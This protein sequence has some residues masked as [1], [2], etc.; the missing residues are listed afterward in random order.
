MNRIIA[1]LGT[2]DSGLGIGDSGLAIPDFR[3]ALATFALLVLI[4]GVSAGCGVR[5]PY[6]APVPAA[7]TAWVEAAPP[8]ADIDALS[9]WW[10]T[11]G[12]PV[13]T[14]LVR[15]AVAGNLEVRT[16]IS[17]LR[18]ARASVVSSRAPLIPTADASGSMRG[19]GR[20][21]DSGLGGTSQ[22]YSLG[23]DASWEID[24][25]GGIRSAIDAATATAEARDA[26][27]QDVLVSLTGEVATDY[28]DVRSVQR[29]LEIARTNAGV[30]EQTL[31]LT[32]FRLQAG[33]GTDLDV[34][35]ALSNLESTRAQL[36][37][38]ESQAAQAIHRVAVLLG[39]PPA[40]LN[41]ELA[42]PGSIPVAPIAVAL[43]VPA[44][45][46]R[47]R[48]DVRS[49]ERQLAAQF[50]QVNAARADLYPTFRLAGSIGLESLSLAR[51]LVPGA[52][53][54]SASP[55]AS[56]RIF[57]RQ[58][59]RQNLVIQ[60]E[61]QEQAARTYETR[62]LGALQDVEDSLT[63]L[64]QEQLRRDHLSAAAAAAEQAADLSLQLYTAGLRDFRDVLD[65][66]RSLLSLQDQL[67]SSGA[68]VSTDLVRL[69]KSLGGGWTASSLVPAKD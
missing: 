63:A 41:A 46:L 2:R 14:S 35:Q 60:S 55:S 43:G 22:S 19:T 49:A 33:L 9:Q 16:A 5:R 4:F 68:S 51:L 48:P 61:R 69:Y 1:G 26:D 17:R 8:A 62:V 47:R 12:D 27:L 11:F 37:S 39:Q 67:A 42:S 15:R 25:F 3:R 54:W 32:R 44:E 59:L 52:S 34:Q 30:Q 36:A 45:T 40:A 28:I 57:N 21:S 64:A 20:G 50:A 56:T 10:E 18:E 29:R 6:Q 31:D 13:L 58:Q 23:I 53:L 7:P 38:L 24:V 65:A 66:Q